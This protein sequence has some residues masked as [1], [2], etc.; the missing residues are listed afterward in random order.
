MITHGAWIQTASGLAYDLEDPKP[1]QID[2]WD[3]ASA[4]ANSTRYNGHAG[5]YSIAEHSVRVWQWVRD[6]GAGIDAQRS[7]LTH[8]AHEAATGDVPSPVKKALGETW[9]AFERKHEI[10]FR[11]RLRVALDL[12]PIVKVADLTLLATEKRDLLDPRAYR[13]NLARLP[14]WIPMPPPMDTRIAPWD[15]DRAC[16]MFLEACRTL[17]IS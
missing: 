12:P 5:R 7:A 13:D 9:R 17:G 10:A 8:D 14:P 1:E 6:T 2:L 4:L 15:P 16:F 3:V 11:E